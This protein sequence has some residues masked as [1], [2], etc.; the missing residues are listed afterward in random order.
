MKWAQAPGKWSQLKAKVKE[1][2]RELTDDDVDK[3]AGR[4]EALAAQVQQRYGIT[5]EQ[6]EDQ[7]SNF[8]ALHDLEG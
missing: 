8:E 1:E 4:R 7:V 3:I 5:R 2:W 6:A